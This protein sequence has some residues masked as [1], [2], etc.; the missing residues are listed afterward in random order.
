MGRGFTQEYG[1]TYEDTHSQMAR[2]ETW[3]I[4]LTLAIQHK[5]HVKQWD[6]VAAYLNAPLT[7]EVY[8]K[9]G[10]ECWRL[11]KALYGLKQAGHEWYNTLRNI[12]TKS[13]LQRSIG[14]P[15]VFYKKGS[16]IIAT[17]VDDMAAFA[18]K[19]STITTTELA[20]EQ[21][22]ELEKL[23][24]PS[25]LLGMELI[26]ESG[27][28]KLTQK[29]AIGNLMKEFG[30]TTTIPTKSLPLNANDYAEIQ[31]ETTPELHKKYQS[32]VGSLLYIAR[33][34]RP[35]ITLHTNLLGRRTSHA[36]PSNLK[37]ELQVLRY[38][39]SSSED[40]IK[41]KGSQ[42]QTLEKSIIIKGYADASYG[43]EMLRGYKQ[44]TYIKLYKN[45]RYL[46][47][48]LEYVPHSSG[49]NN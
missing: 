39:A 20:I 14:D 19:E 16:I 24:Q 3:R 21:Y 5:W 34:T 45:N 32:L 36:T 25:K 40:G 46:Q 6:V 42:E 30:I 9:H 41:I 31:E 27:Y 49:Y 43:G 15:E 18:P 8:V 47:Y 7:H 48:L 37:A 33:H 28:V 1:K 2:S 10:E 12:M 4:L 13:G 23:G 44:Y 38:L 35:E 26:W 17:H 29:A 11:H 22:V